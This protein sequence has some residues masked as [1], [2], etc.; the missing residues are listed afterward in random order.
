MKKRTLGLVLTLVMTLTMGVSTLAAPSK[1]VA[2]V[3]SKVEAIDNANKDVE[4]IVSKPAKAVEESVV[5][6][7]KKPETIKNV[8][9]NDYSDKLSVLDVLDISVKGDESQVKW[10]ITMKLNIAGVNKDTKIYVLHYVDG[11]WNNVEIV[12]KGTGYVT[13]KVDSLSPFAFVVDKDTLSAKSPSTGEP[14]MTTA[15]TMMVVVAAVGMIV[16]KRKATV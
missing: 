7:V 12:E 8:L 10:P 16:L 4:I 5:A 11:K 13:I 14:V 2:G 3:I 6:E 15:V 1:E 9:G